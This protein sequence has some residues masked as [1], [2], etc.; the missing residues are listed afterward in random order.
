MKDNCRGVKADLFASSC[1]IN[2]KC[3][4]AAFNKE[5]DTEKAAFTVKKGTIVV[6]TD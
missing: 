1:I 3:L 4:K 2:S 6:N 5:I